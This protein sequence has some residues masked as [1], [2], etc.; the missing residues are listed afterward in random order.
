MDDR[1]R[2]GFYGNNGGVIFLIKQLTIRRKLRREIG[3]AWSVGL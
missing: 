1:F 3:T 2:F